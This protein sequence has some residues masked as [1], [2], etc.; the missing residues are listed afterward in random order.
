MRVLSLFDG[1]SCGRIALD[2]AGLHV[3][4]YHASEIDPYAIKVS[5]SN[6]PDITQVGDVCGVNGEDYPDL[7]L[8]L[9]GSPCQGF[10]YAGGKLNFEDPR[11]ALFFEF[12][13]ILK[14]ARPRFFL[15]ENVRMKPEWVG[16]INAELGVEP[17]AINSALVSAQN[18]NRLYWTNIP[19]LSQP[20]DK[21]ILFDEILE[22]LTLVP[23][24]FDVGASQLAKITNLGRLSEGACKVAFR[25]PS[26]N[27]E[28]AVCLVARDYKGIPGRE[29]HNAAMQDGVLRRLT[30][31]EYERLQTVP[32]GYTSAVSKSQ[33][34]K[35]LGNGWTVDVVAHIL[36][37]IPED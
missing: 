2:R 6:Y 29:H 26:S 28:K 21:G 34:I 25:D 13:R 22:P 33:R 8:L 1:M 17:M 31:V 14:E 24:S 12:V 30:P 36:S 23:N 7:D 18:R 27:C 4:S 10:S 5:E 15:L 9:G 35:M 37:G 19:N 3:D 16:V 32:E 11:S 20:E